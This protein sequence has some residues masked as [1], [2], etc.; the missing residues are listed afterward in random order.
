MRSDPVLEVMHSIEHTI[1]LCLCNV[2]Y[3]LQPGGSND[4]DNNDVGSDDGNDKGEES[5]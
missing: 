2:G 5:R 3:A 4:D 1:S